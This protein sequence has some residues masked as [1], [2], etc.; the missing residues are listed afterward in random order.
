MN[1]TKHHSENLDAL[2]FLAFFIILVLHVLLLPAPD[3]FSHPFHRW[4]LYFTSMGLPG[5][6][7]FFV[8]SSFLIT[9]IVLEEYE[10]TGEFAAEKFWTRRSLRIRPLYF[11]ALQSAWRSI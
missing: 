1:R 3:I 2:G 11:T 5:V 6:D 4:L 7:F 9:W 10:H 8:L